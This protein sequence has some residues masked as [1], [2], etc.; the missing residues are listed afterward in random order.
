M[1]RRYKQIVTICGVLLAVSMFAVGGVSAAG[2][3]SD[4]PPIDVNSTVEIYDGNNS[5]NSTVELDHARGYDDEALAVIDCSVGDCSSSNLSAFSGSGKLEVVSKNNMAVSKNADGWEF[6]T[7]G[8]SPEI[9]VEFDFDSTPS[10]GTGAFAVESTGGLEF[11]SNNS[12]SFGG[13]IPISGGSEV[14]SISNSTDITIYDNGSQSGTTTLPYDVGNISGMRIKATQNATLS[15]F[16]FWDRTVSVGEASLLHDEYRL[17][18]FV[19]DSTTTTGQKLPENASLSWDVNRLRDAE[20][21]LKVQSYDG[22]DWITEETLTVE[23]TAEYDIGVDGGEEYRFV[24]EPNSTVDSGGG[25]YFFGGG[26]S[27]LNIF[28]VVVTRGT[29]TGLSG[30]MLLLLALAFYYPG[31]RLFGRGSDQ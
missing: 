15:G 28:G 27:T 2:N 19:P 20:T 23:S 22:A 10:N 11:S 31:M 16:S 6:V 4:Y 7:D 26:T 18:A 12:G 17:G 8:T 5:L 25:G 9:V 3:A 24:S 13:Y 21:T 1:T 29:A 14:R 30:I